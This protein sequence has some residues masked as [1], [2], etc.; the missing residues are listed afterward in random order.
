[1]PAPAGDYVRR[2][3][4]ELADLPPTRIHTPWR[5]DAAARC[6]LGYPDPLVELS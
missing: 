2:Y 6:R 1:M 3:V 4:P 5:L